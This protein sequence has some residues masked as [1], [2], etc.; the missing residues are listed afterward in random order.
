MTKLVSEPGL[1]LYNLG[2]VTVVL[3][4][5]LLHYCSIIRFCHVFDQSSLFEYSAKSLGSLICC[6]FEYYYVCCLFSV[7]RCR[8]RVAPP[9]DE[10]D[11]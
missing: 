10:F 1:E 2:R 9:V 8:A 4:C 6:V 11:Y 7:L 5:F 3:L